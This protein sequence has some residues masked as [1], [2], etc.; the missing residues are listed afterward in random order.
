MA[1]AFSYSGKPGDSDLD[2]VRFTIGDTIKLR[3]MFSD[4]EILYQ[5]TQT[6]NI[7]LAGAELLEVKSR[8][9]AR[10]A[11]VSV[12]DVR[13]AFSKL[14]ESMKKCAEQL[15]SD[16]V[17]L[18]KPF[19]GGLTKTGK[20]ALAEN[21]DDVQPAFAIGQTDNPFAVQINRDFEFLRGVTDGF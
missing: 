11:D 1:K 10:L 18:V 17:R 15:R 13:K 14:S 2:A 4:D 3:P 9:F 20:R 19:F 16:A 12:G 5:V 7:K 8:E 6:P 21:I